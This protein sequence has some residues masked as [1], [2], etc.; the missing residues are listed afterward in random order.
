MV[1]LALGRIAHV[2]A[3]ILQDY[4][5]QHSTHFLNLPRMKYVSSWTTMEFVRSQVHMTRH[6]IAC[7]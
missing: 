3:R 5:F 4:D 7:I 6:V 1:K 2:D